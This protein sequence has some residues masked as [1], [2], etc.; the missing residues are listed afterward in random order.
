MISQLGLATISMKNHW[1][2]A[3]RAPSEGRAHHSSVARASLR[4]GMVDV[5]IESSIINHQMIT[6]HYEVI[7]PYS[8]IWQPN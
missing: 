3:A 4:H 7:A 5:N 8:I 1:Y 6:S 2:H